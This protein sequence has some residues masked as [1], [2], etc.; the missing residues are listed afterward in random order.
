MN[1][2]N[3]DKSM[4]LDL[5]ALVDDDRRSHETAAVISDHPTQRAS[6][7][8]MSRKESALAS[9]VRQGM[10]RLTRGN[11]SASQQARQL[12]AYARLLVDN[13]LDSGSSEN[14][15]STRRPRKRDS[16]ARTSRPQSTGQET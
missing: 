4:V 3:V 11:P 2:N 6:F 8:A 9:T 15:V 14:G 13:Y 5:L 12:D 1:M 10:A 16:A 7:A